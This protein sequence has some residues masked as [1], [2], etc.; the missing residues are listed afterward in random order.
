MVPESCKGPIFLGTGACT[1]V[2]GST[3]LDTGASPECRFDL[4]VRRLYQASTNQNW[5]T[6]FSR[7][8]DEARLH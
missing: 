7:G 2:V 3:I 8:H 1:P 4:G 5:G 6:R